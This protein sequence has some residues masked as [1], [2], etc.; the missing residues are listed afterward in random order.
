MARPT[1]A[2]H[3]AKLVLHASRA[4]E[5][6]RLTA[7]EV[8]AREAQQVQP[9]NP[10]AEYIIGRVA[11]AIGRPDLARHHYRNAAAAGAAA[12]A[13]KRL[14]ALGDAPE[15]AGPPERS[16]PAYIL[17]KPWGAGFWSDVNHV[18]GQLL[19]AEIERRTPVVHWGRGSL[20]RD[21]DVRN[22][23]DSFFEPVS[24]ATLDDLAR[25]R[26][27][28]Y[29]PKW[30]SAD[31]DAPEH[32]KWVGRD[33]RLGLELL[34]RPERVVVSDF[35]LRIYSLLPWIPRWHP[36]H[37]RDVESVYR[38][39][40]AKYIRPR[41]EIVRAVDTF[42]RRHFEG[43][44]VLAVHIRATDKIVED[45]RLPRINAEYEPRVDRFVEEHEDARVFLLTD[46]REVMRRFRARYGKRLIATD[47][48]RSDSQIGIHF[49][50]EFP[51]SQIAREVLTDVLLAT[52]CEAFLGL[53]SSSVSTFV[54]H[55]KA[56]APESC[57]LLGGVINH[58][59]RNP[60][61]YL[62]NRIPRGAEPN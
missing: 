56:W 39:L 33:S 55:L 44:R 50:A 17:I 62:T 14:K 5:S 18:L 46:G 15:E 23:W 48:I 26:G 30:N 58:H 38:T 6:N 52:R 34:G 16:E 60:Y 61:V 24:D 36:L 42:A 35:N 57:T 31:L 51:R 27:G 32:N 4:L 19:V 13:R 10:R 49:Q 2:S 43:H 1:D 37:G 29:P 21:S 54:Y 41:A 7:A 47:C 12:D 3:P 9:E 11:E 40:A 59:G 45:P 8:L 25:L 22:A 28:V 20:Y 53:G